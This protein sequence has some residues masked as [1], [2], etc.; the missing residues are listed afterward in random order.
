MLNYCCL[1]VAPVWGKGKRN[2]IERRV[3]MLEVIRAIKAG[4]QF[5]GPGVAACFRF[6]IEGVRLIGLPWLRACAS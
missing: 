6:N 5:P 2:T 4:K 3:S 1:V